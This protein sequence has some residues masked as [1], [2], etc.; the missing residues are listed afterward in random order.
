MA[1]AC[2]VPFNFLSR[3]IVILQFLKAPKHCIISYAMVVL[4]II[5]PW[6]LDYQDP[7]L[8]RGVNSSLGFLPLFNLILLYCFS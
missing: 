8:Q 2:C 6:L 4:N 3:L 1:N 5:A 7:C